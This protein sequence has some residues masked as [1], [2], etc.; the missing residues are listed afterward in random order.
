ME[1]LTCNECMGK[2]SRL[3]RVA[4]LPARLEL[5]P[6][7]AAGAEREARSPRAL[8]SEMLFGAG[9]SGTPKKK[10]RPH[11]NLAGTGPELCGWEEAR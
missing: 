10:G 2:L 5:L 4:R 11:A 6:V 7:G 3:L 9:S 8:G 1:G